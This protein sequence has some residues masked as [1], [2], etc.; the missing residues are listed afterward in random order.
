MR[1]SN[2]PY[3]APLFPLLFTSLLFLRALGTTALPLDS[4][5]AEQPNDALPQPPP[6]ARLEAGWRF[7]EPNDTKSGINIAKNL[8][9][10]PDGRLG[11]VQ[12]PVR[13]P[14]TTPPPPALADVKNYP[15]KLTLLFT[16]HAFVP[17]GAVIEASGAGVSVVVGSRGLAALQLPAGRHQLLL[18]A[19]GIL[20]RLNPPIFIPVGSSPVIRNYSVPFFWLRGSV[21]GPSNEVVA[22]AIIQ[23][24]FCPTWLVTCGKSS[25]KQ[26]AA[27]AGP[28]GG[29]RARVSRGYFSSIIAR[30]PP[31]T[32][33]LYVATALKPRTI[34]N[35]SPFPAILQKGFIVSGRIVR[36]DGVQALNLPPPMIRFVSEKYPGYIGD[37]EAVGDDIN[38]FVVAPSRSG[39]FAVVLPVGAYTLQAHESGAPLEP[40]SELLVPRLVVN[41][42][43]SMNTI[44]LRYARLTIRAID[45]ATGKP[46]IGGFFLVSIHRGFAKIASSFVDVTSDFNGTL[47]TLFL[48][49]GTVQVV[50][51][52]FKPWGAET[53]PC[54]TDGPKEVSLVGGQVETLITRLPICRRRL[55]G[56]LRYPNG[57]LFTGLDFSL[58]ARDSDSSFA[59]TVTPDGKYSFRVTP[60]TYDIAISLSLFMGSDWLTYAT[61]KVDYP[62]RRVVVNPSNDTV[63]D[64]VPPIHRTEVS[65]V[66]SNGTQ[67]SVPATLN[68][69]LDLPDRSRVFAFFSVGRFFDEP[70]RWA[71][72]GVYREVKFQFSKFDDD[73]SLPGRIRLPDFVLD[74]D[75]NFRMVFEREQ[76]LVVNGTLLRGSGSPCINCLVVAESEDG[77]KV[78]VKTGSDGGFVVRVRRGIYNITSTARLADGGPF[79]ATITVASHFAI[80]GDIKPT[81]RLPRAVSYTAAVVDASGKPATNAYL[82]INVPETNLS[83]TRYSPNGRF[84][85]HG[86]PANQ[87]RWALVTVWLAN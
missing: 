64:I 22:G 6:S 15:V 43:I 67:I 54:G 83:V 11:T 1:H 74:R 27:I 38:S 49:P 77:F 24:I 42:N 31:N 51:S 55:S 52:F 12:V 3:S 59:T 10:L 65:T 25:D 2:L 60:G 87:V 14:E 63:E 71:V 16:D 57:T 30:P 19:P 36:G 40:R 50:A 29:F 32:P 82:A 34:T 47:G 61:G 7:P 35:N 23:G 79:I 41:S 56:S 78:S 18:R 33:A 75:R 73:P 20:E 58:V 84:V 5:V 85:I 80:S 69:Y 66:D 72:D 70:K 48:A 86:L 44:A 28:A 45:V 37:W 4:F 21:R 76:V 62:F 9:W 53:G 39:K 68:G 13:G 81:W 46:P 8:A 26:F 17:T